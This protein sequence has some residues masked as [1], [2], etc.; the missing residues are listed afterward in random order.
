MFLDPGFFDR[1]TMGFS[2]A[3]HIILAVIGVALPVI[4]L[5]SEYLGIRYEDKEYRVLSKRLTTAF[6]I[7][8][9]IGTA[10]GTLV[11]INLFFLWP[12]FMALVGKVAILPVYMEVFAFFTETIFLAIY[13]YSSD[14]FRNKYYHIFLMLLIAIGAAASAAFITVLNSFMNTPVGFNISTFLQNGTLAQINPLAVFTAPA[15]G[16]EVSHVLATS[17]FA[18]TA[19]FLAYFAY[20]FLRNRKPVERLYYS[21]AV[22][23]TFAITLIAALASVVTGTYSIR[24]LA[25]IQ[26]EKFAAIELD[27]N[28]STYAPE[29]IGGIYAGNTIKYGLTIPGLQSFMETDKFSGAV[30]TLDEFPRSTWPPLIIH[31]MFDFMVFLGF[32]IGMFLI[33]VLAYYYL[34]DKKIF[35]NRV[36]LK[37]LVATGIFAVILLENGWMVDEFGR[38][39]WII[40]NVM[41]VQSAANTST[42]IIPIAIMIVALYA[43]IIPVTYYFLRRIFAGRDLSRELMK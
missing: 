32:G 43:V 15:V 36:I 28:T 9:A 8:F 42:A 11:A 18:G 26:P 25:G 34:K 30:P 4:I 22:R 6:L 14:F 33:L 10:S 7:F 19:I 27:I 3:I 31:D 24:A 17:Y 5:T 21:K 2:L 38:Q 39:P 35:E 16:I 41:T 29:I 20:S 12:S 23:L 13:L 1:F 37:L 40:Y